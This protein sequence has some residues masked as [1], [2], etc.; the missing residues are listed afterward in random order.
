MTWKRFCYYVSEILQGLLA[1]VVGYFAWAGMKSYYVQL[2]VQLEEPIVFFTLLL[3]FFFGL[4]QA[5]KNEE[6]EEEVDYE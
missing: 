4:T 6:D 1:C 2:P 3:G 5:G